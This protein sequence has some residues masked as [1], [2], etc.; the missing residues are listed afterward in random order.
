MNHSPNE[1]LQQFKVQLLCKC[2]N[3]LLSATPPTQPEFCWEL[4]G[5][6]VFSWIF[7]QKESS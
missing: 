2:S 5:M 4:M 6:H 7:E 3:L 1:Q